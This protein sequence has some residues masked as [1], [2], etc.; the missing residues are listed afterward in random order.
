MVDEERSEPASW[1]DW[2]IVGL[3]IAGLALMLILW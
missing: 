1:R 2:V 3:L